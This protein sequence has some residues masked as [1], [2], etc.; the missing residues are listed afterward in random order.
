MFYIYV[1]ISNEDLDTMT[2]LMSSYLVGMVPNRNLQ[3]KAIDSGCTIE[4]ALS[5]SL[6][7]IFDNIFVGDTTIK[8]IQTGGP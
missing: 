5:C 3:S 7:V 8:S 2:K 4:D 1:E 6:G